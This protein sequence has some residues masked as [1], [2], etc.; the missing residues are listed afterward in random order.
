M[1]FIALF[2]SFLLTQMAFA[3]SRPTPALPQAA[4]FAVVGATIHVGNGQVLQNKV[5]VVENGKITAIADAA[6]AGMSVIAAKGKEL[7][8]GF[9]ACNTFLGLRDVDAVRA[10]NDFSE[11][12]VSNPNARALI[13]YNADNRI[14]PTVR[15]MGILLAQSVPAGGMLRGKSTVFELDGWNWDDSAYRIDDGLHLNW[16]SLYQN[17]GWWAEPGPTARNKEYD[18][19]TQRIKQY[20]AEAKAY[21]EMK[22]PT[23]NARF[24]AMRGVLNGTENLYIHVDNAKGI[25]D[26]VNFAKAYTSKIVLMGAEEGWRIADFLLEN[27]VSVVLSETNRLPARTDDD[28]DLPYKM[29]AL[30][31]AKGVPFTFSIDGA[32]EQRDFVFQAGQAIGFGLEYE[33][34]VEAGTL[35][36]ARILGIDKTVGSIEVGKDATFILCS[37]DIFE[38]R[39]GAVEQAFIRGKNLD[40]N[41]VQKELYE[42][43]KKR[44]KSN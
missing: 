19:T 9:I 24:E 23:H 10:T 27:K 35:G 30:L 40:L 18:E 34:A 43:Y 25:I 42:R 39:L 33:K 15:S 31:S 21:N 12:G 36:A 41:N 3:Q 14:N 28:I 38:P 32:W 7:Y 6:P 8:P 2:S 29:P 13:A 11:V 4:P 1:R 16:A 17:S 5:V 44:Y 37:G 20:F 22:S 26:A